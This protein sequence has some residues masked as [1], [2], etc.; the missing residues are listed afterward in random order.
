MESKVQTKSN[1]LQIFGKNKDLK[2]EIAADGA[3]DIEMM[4]SESLS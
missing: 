3:E 4:I 2:K 1:P